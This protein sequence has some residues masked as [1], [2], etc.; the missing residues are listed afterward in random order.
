MNSTGS[1]NQQRHGRQVKTFVTISYLKGKGFPVHPYIGA[2]PRSVA[3]LANGCDE[4]Q[5]RVINLH[6][7]HSD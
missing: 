2:S 5:G 1:G 6:I 7:Q 4:A 3:S